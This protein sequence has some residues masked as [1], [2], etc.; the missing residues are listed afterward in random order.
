MRKIVLS[1]HVSLDGYVA[2][3]NNEM[4]W[5]HADAQLFDYIKTLTDQASTALYGRVTYEMM[6]AYW[7]TAAQQPNASN[8]DI[9]HSHWYNKVNKVVL[10]TTLQGQ[11][12]ADTHFIGDN[13]V[14]E[15]TQLKASPGQNILMFGSPSAAQALMNF[16]LIDEYWLFLNP[17]ILGDGKPLFTK[18]A[19]SQT[20][21][22]VSSQ[23]FASGVVELRYRKK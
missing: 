14:Q 21:E 23:V 7:P 15:I 19:N 20:L 4:N 1:M 11:D 2:G 10:S 22:L 13:L 5:I 18:L 17:Y 8:H 16:N 6:N 3:T 9:E 12:T